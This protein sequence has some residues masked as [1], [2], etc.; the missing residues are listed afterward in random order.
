MYSFFVLLFQFFLYDYSY[1]EAY[2]IA[3]ICYYAC[4]FLVCLFGLRAISNK[5]VEQAQR[6]RCAITTF[7]FIYIG[8][9]AFWFYCLNSYYYD[10]YYTPY[11]PIGGLCLTSIL[12]R[13]SKNLERD[14]ILLRDCSTY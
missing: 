4:M 11:Y 3:S 2:E 7:L 14:C 8:Y 1:V 13:K 9:I 10:G 12:L 6:F 5:T